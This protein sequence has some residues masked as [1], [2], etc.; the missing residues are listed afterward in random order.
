MCSLHGKLGFNAKWSPGV[1]AHNVFDPFCG[2][3]A[4]RGGGAALRDALVSVWHFM[5]A[6]HDRKCKPGEKLAARARRD[7]LQ[8]TLTLRFLDAER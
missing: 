5:V 7:C 3:D 2:E 6:L 4:A 1:T 8:R